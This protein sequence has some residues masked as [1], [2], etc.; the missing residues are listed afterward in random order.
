MKKTPTLLNLKA[1]DVEFIK[2]RPAISVF[3]DNLSLGA[4]LEKAYITPKYKLCKH[5]EE[6]EGIAKIYREYNNKN[7]IFVGEGGSGKTSAFLRLYTNTEEDIKGIEHKQFFY[8]FA[9]DLKGDKENG[10]QTPNSYKKMLREIINTGTDLNG[11]LLLD[12]LEEAYLNNGKKASELLKMLADSNIVFWVSCRTSFYEKLS[13]DIIPCFAEKI[14]VNAWKP[15]DF[16]NFI[17][18][19]LEGKNDRDEI[20]ARIERLKKQAASLT[21]RPLFATMILFVA[22]DPGINDVRNE[23]E[24]IELFLE[25][26][27]KREQKEKKIS[28]T[29]NKREIAYKELRDIALSIYLRTDKRPRYNKNIRIFRDLLVLSDSN[30]GT[31]IL[32][33]YHREFLVYFIVN[34]LMDAALYHPDRIVWWFSQTFYD[35]IT[36]M[37]KPVLAGMER[38]KI[39]II[40]NN[41]FSVYRRTY[42]KDDDIKEEF[43]ALGL[44]PEESFLKLRDEMLY[45]ILRLPNVDYNTFV[46]YAY[47]HSTD[48]MLFLGIAYGM[49]AIDPS[50]PYTL[51]FAEKLEPG[52]EN[53]EEIRNRGWGM[54]FFGDVDGNGYGYNDSEKKPWNKLRENRL[55]RLTDNK[56]KY[57]TRVLDIPLLYCF[58]A[59]RG[60]SDC[61]SFRDYTIIKNTDISLPCFGKKQRAFMQERRGQLVFEYRKQLLLNEIKTNPCITNKIQKERIVKMADDR[62]KIL[63]EIDEELAERILKQ[64]EHKEIVC[65]NIKS[66]LEQNGTDIEKYKKQL[67][68]PEHHKIYREKFDKRIKNCKVLIISANYVEGVI[69]T[70]RLMQSSGKEKLDAYTIDGHLYQFASINSI[71]VLHIWPTDKSSYTRYG[72][73]SAVDAALDRFS[74][75]YVLSVGVAF[76]I[77]PNK[78]SLGD[79]LIAKNLVFYDSF[80]KVTNGKI[81]L[82]PQDTYQI[83]A[84]QKAQVHQLEMETPPESVG[85]FKWFFNALLTGGTVLSD[86]DE[87]EK[88]L[89]AA[90]GLG[91]E[92]VGGEMEAGGIYHACQRIKNRKIPFFIIKGICDWGAEKNGWNDVIDNRQDGNVIKDCVQAFAC[93]NAYD[94]MCYIL[95][96]LNME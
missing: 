35:D 38:D 65:K 76:G 13:D 4:V 79:V 96:Q 73:F 20:K 84:D 90:T 61:T 19:C 63:I 88:L 39:E 81:K 41:L 40:Y 74:P 95:S 64:I 24:L 26:W 48:T 80:N 53:E 18:K 22:E 69:V 72:S 1:A 7:V 29:N 94:A 93:D 58:Y 83:D 47:E 37:I 54:C 52:K 89:E 60:F 56:E 70:R 34:A 78:Q 30:T 92:I 62:K 43:K 11:I 33:F 31:T 66:F 27:I 6:C 75:K 77:D 44:S 21:Q 68:L 86:V 57:V 23:Y 25:K 45:F 15:D 16:E 67:F 28:F 2:N 46:H 50:N 51:K 8:F 49:A 71:P 42:E 87:K 12:G 14:N 59:S 36:N 5:G 55:R 17:S 82:R 32:S 91:Y 3:R 9:P 10:K 85:K